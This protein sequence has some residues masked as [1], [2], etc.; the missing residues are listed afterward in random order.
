M[1]YS[2][3][4][5]GKYFPAVQGTVTV[6]TRQLETWKTALRTALGRWQEK[7]KNNNNKE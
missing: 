3:R 1:F 6:I 2:D 5:W 4:N 7:N